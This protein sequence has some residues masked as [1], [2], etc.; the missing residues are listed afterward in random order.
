MRLVMHVLKK[1][2]KLGIDNET[3]SFK[4]INQKLTEEFTEVSKAI[5]NYS[6]DKTLENL[7]EVIRE[8]FDLIQVCILILFKSNNISKELGE[9]NLIEDI[10]IEHKDKLSDRGWIYETGIEIDV[11]E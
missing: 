3:I 9:E 2:L 10:N 1:N 8:T 5:V 4:E 6:Y 7:K 11:K